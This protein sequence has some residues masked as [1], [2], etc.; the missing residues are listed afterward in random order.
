QEHHQVGVPIDDRVEEGAEGRDLARGA[1]Q[2]AVEEVAEAGQDQQDAAGADP[3]ADERRRRQEAHAEPD[4]GQVVRPEMQMAIERQPDR[5]DPA[6][7][8]LA[9]TSEHRQIGRPRP[10]SS[11]SRPWLSAALFWTLPAWASCT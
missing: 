9:V 4:Q 11:A 7:D 6:A 3:R 2:R 10:W 1:R 8:G 5:I